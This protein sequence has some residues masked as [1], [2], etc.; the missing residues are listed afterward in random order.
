MSSDPILETLAKLV[1][2]HEGVAELSGSQ[3]LNVL[4]TENIA[5]ALS[6]ASETTF[7]TKADVADTY[8]VSYHSELLNKF[9]SL[10]ASRGSVTALGVKYNGYLKTTGFE[11]IVDSKIV[12]QNGLIR[13]LSA[14][15]SITRYIWCHVAYTANADE[16]RI[17]MVDFIIN[18]LTGVTPVD[19]GDALLW[20]SDR[21]TVDSGTVKPE[22]SPDELSSLIEN[23]AAKLIKAELNNWYS[24]LNRALKRDEERLDSY[25]ESISQEI[26]RKIESR[27]L[28][29][30]DKEKE[31]AR[32]EATNRELSRKKADVRE[33]YALQVEAYLHSAMIIHLPTVHIQCEFVR[34]KAKRTVTLVWNPFTKNIEPLRCEVTGEPV[35]SF[36]LD[37]RDAKIISP[38]VW[39]TL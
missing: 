22:T 33:R 16:K 15:P 2:L 37:D 21:I 30:E 17:G 23:T 1:E 5:K 25:Y 3:T 6:V 20:T 8:F 12:P 31:L 35:Y 19:I 24:K 36:Y 29:G 34:K 9:S 14:T 10:L 11:K 28:E 13:Y 27:G 32:I 4:L 26:R 39:G 38:T 7:S 18:E